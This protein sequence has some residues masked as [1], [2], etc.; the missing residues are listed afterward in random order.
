LLWVSRVL[1]PSYSEAIGVVITELSVVA[2]APLANNNGVTC[3]VQSC[4]RS[5]KSEYL[6]IRPVHFWSSS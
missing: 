6:L 3:P 4:W 5:P 2:S 1:N